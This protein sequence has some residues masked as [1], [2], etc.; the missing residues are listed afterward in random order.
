M[1]ASGRLAEAAWLAS[2]D[3]A[4]SRAPGPVCQSGRRA[5]AAG[6]ASQ[7][8]AAFRVPGLVYR[9]GRRAS[10][11]AVTFLVVIAPAVFLGVAEESLK[12]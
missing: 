2:P 12:P 3:F 8:F 5:S 6:R 7:D 10:A 11:A 9:A 1:V 4:A